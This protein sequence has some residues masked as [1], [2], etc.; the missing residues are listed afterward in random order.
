MQAT[1]PP[2]KLLGDWVRTNYD[3]LEITTNNIIWQ[4]WYNEQRDIAVQFDEVASLPT[5]A[6]SDFSAETIISIVYI[7][8][9][10]RDYGVHRNNPNTGISLEQID[11]TIDINL[12]VA[13]EI[14]TNK[15][16]NMINNNP[17]ALESENVPT[18]EADTPYEVPM[19]EWKTSVY[20][21]IIPVRMTYV[22][23]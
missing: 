5:A 7:H 18:I 15:I 21:M 8:I 1:H 17:S 12:P 11:V 6:N 22:E 10:V 14:V 4:Q 19:A 20:R 23:S 13:L 2:A 3:S 16:F 9:F